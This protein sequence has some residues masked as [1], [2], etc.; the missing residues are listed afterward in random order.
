MPPGK[1]AKT[2]IFQVFTEESRKRLSFAGEICYIINN[3]MT[4][5]YVRPFLGMR[6]RGVIDRQE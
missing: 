5:V 4:K 6:G 1:M 2:T 3:M